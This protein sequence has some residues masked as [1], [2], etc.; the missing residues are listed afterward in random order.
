MGFLPERKMTIK[1]LEAMDEGVI[2]ARVLA[3]MC[4]LWMTEKQVAEMAN[5]YELTNVA[6]WSK[7]DD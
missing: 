6:E 7:K 3:E 4:I 5:V 1:L 2:E